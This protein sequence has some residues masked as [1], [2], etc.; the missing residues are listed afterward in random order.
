M[1]SLETKR[2][3]RMQ[4]KSVS[5]WSNEDFFYFYFKIKFKSTMTL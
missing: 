5:I 1:F 4:I 3:I 2:L